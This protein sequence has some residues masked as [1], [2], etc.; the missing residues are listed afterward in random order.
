LTPFMHAANRNPA[1]YSTN[2]MLLDS[3]V[4]LLTTYHGSARNLAVFVQKLFTNWS[5]V[6][7]PCE[8][9]FVPEFLRIGLSSHHSEM[10]AP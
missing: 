3:S 5:S 10:T 6:G 7:R 4:F 1:D 2:T 8:G 9:L